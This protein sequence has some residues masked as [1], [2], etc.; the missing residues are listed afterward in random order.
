MDEVENARAV[1]GNVA[2]EQVLEEKKRKLR[3]LLE[4]MK[5]VGTE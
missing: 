5:I 1:L 4:R 2:G 3:E